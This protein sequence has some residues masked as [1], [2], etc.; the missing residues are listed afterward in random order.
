MAGAFGEASL[1]RREIVGRVL[2]YFALAVAM[3]LRDPGLRRR[4]GETA[5][6]LIL[7]DLTLRHQAENLARIYR[8]L[9]P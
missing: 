4:I 8:E 1:R 5:R 7:E 2:S 9:A 6:Q 3:L